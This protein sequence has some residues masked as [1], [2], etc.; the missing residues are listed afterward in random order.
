MECPE[1]AIYRIY[2][3]PLSLSLSKAARDFT[4]TNPLAPKLLAYYGERLHSGGLAWTIS[5]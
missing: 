5:S 1:P 3:A 4:G 2:P